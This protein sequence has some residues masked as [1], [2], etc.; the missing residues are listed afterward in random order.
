MTQILEAEP[1]ERINPLDHQDL[2]WHLARKYGNRG[3]DVQ[4]LAQAAQFGLLRAIDRYDPNR[5]IK[6]ATYAYWWVRQAI[7]SAISKNSP[8]ASL[9]DVDVE[10]LNQT[11][12]PE[13][14]RGF[15]ESILGLLDALP[16]RHAKILRMR[17][18]LDPY[19]PHKLEEIG[20][21]LGVS[22]QRVQQVQIEAIKRLR[23]LAEEAQLS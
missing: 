15:L 19:E 7:V 5:N 8:I 14:D 3:V 18:G 23:A 4:D 17:F 16:S 12:T 21:V 2:V 11:P 22:K 10:Q 6:F 1:V 20:Q 9:G 13:V